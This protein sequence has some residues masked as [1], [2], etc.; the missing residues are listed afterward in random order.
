MAGSIAIDTRID[1]QLVERF[2]A[3]LLKISHNAD[4][5][6]RKLTIAV[7]GGA[8]SLALLLLAHAAMPGRVD[9]V[10]VDHGLRPES[11]D[12][13]EFVKSIC[14]ELSID[15]ATLN[16]R[17][18]PGNIQDAARRARYSAI[19]DWLACNHAHGDIFAT[20]HHADDQAETLVMRLNRS[21]GLAGLAGVRPGH[22]HFPNENTGFLL[23]RPLL[24]WRRAE[25]AQ[26]VADAGITPVDDPSNSDNAFDRVRVRKALADANWIDPVAWSKSAALLSEASELIDIFA[27][28][29]AAS[30]VQQTEKGFEYRP[31][32]FRL[33][34]IEVIRLCFAKMGRDI[35]RSDADR[36]YSRLMSGQNASLANILVSKTEEFDQEEHVEIDVFRFQPEP[37]RRTG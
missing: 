9:A 30:Q 16:V 6:G 36:I 13:A 27:A 23:V 11:G 7:S 28:R 8:D 5:P 34:S 31:T 35:S 3:D 15:H 29:E 14:R 4:L 17:L 22:W 19:L 33:V 25:L 26:I 12:E 2:R 21:S 1:P 10:T 20:A 32:G 18:E 37:P 24:Q